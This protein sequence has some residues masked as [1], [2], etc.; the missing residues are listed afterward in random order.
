MTDL[1]DKTFYE[2]LGVSNTASS[3]EIREAYKSIARAFHPDSNF[4]D[5]IIQDEAPPDQEKF[6]KITEAYNTLI[7]EERRKA[8]DEMFP[9]GLRDWN[10]IE[11][12]IPKEDLVRPFARSSDNINSTIYRP[13]GHTGTFRRSTFGAVTNTEESVIEK[14]LKGHSIEPV[15]I[16][17]ERNIVPWFLGLLFFGLAAGMALAYYVA[18]HR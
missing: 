15:D 3:E 4:Y 13:R 16:Q 8:Y 5:E 10:D 1:A 18:T 11:R 2:I 14:A 6:K 9:K 7:N 12:N 17:P